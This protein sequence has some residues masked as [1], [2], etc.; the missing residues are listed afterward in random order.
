MLQDQMFRVNE[1]LMELNDTKL[2]L[3]EFAMLE[4]IQ[5]FARVSVHSKG[6]FLTE[7]SMFD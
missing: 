5:H 3:I 2:T 6:L 1:M 7:V 4:K